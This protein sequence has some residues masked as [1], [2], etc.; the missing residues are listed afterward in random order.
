MEK[1]TK[2]KL[3]KI[4][5]KIKNSNIKTYLMQI[6]KDTANNPHK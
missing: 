1:I 5:I 6:Q 4:F 2:K 3:K